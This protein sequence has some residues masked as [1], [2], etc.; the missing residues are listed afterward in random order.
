MEKYLGT[1]YKFQLPNSYFQLLLLIKRYNL[2]KVL[3]C[4]TATSSYWF[5]NYKWLA[6]IKSEE[7]CSAVL[8]Y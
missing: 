1:W 3:A 6:Y 4:S 2:Y 8:K 7:L 5:V